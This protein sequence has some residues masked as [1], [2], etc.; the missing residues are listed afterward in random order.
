[1]KHILFLII[2]FFVQKNTAQTANFEW[3]KQTGGTSSDISWATATDAS[4]NVYTTG[5]FQGTV[6][7]DP[8]TNVFNLTANG[9]ACAFILKLDAAGN[10]VWATH[11]QVAVGTS[12]GR[13]I[14]VD[15][16]GNV[17]T[18]GFFRGDVDFDPSV[19][20][21]YLNSG[22]A[23]ISDVFVSKL[24]TAG[25]FVWA[26]KLGSASNKD[27]A[28]GIAL[29]SAGNVYTTGVFN[30]GAP[31]IV[32]YAF[33]SKLN[34]LGALVWTSNI[35]NN[36]NAKSAN[37][38]T[39]DALGNIYTTGYF[40]G[41]CLFGNTLLQSNTNSEDIFVTKLDNFGNTV[42]AKA[43]VSS[44]GS[45]GDAAGNAIVTDAN[46]NVYV[47]GH[48][49]NTTDFDPGA[50]NFTL[51]PGDSPY[52]K[53]DA[54]ALK[55]DTGGNFVWAKQITNT[56]NNDN[57]FAITLDATGNVYIAGRYFNTCDFD[58]GAGTFIVNGNGGYVSKLDADGNFILAYTMQGGSLCQ[59]IS[60]NALGNIYTTG[61]LNG[62]T[63]DFDPSASFYNLTSTGFTDG[64][65]HKMC[66]SP[67]VT[68]NVLPSNSICPGTAIT[69]TGSGASTYSWSGPGNPIN[70]VA[71]TPTASATY[72]LT[73]THTNGCPT[74]IEVPITVLP[75]P[76]ITVNSGT[77]CAGQTFTI[78]PTGAATYNIQ[79]GSNVVSPTV[80]TT[81]SVVGT[82]TFGCSSNTETA[83]VTVVNCPQATHLNFDG[84]ND[85]VE[86]PH[87]AG[88]NISN[89]ITIETWI[90]TT[91]PNEH[92]ITTKNEG[93][94]YLAI[95]G[96]NLA[97]GKLTFYLSGISPSG[98]TIGST[99]VSD[100]NWHHVAATYDG[101]FIKLYVDG[102][103]DGQ[104]AQTGT[105]STVLDNIAIGKRPGFNNTAI[106]NGSL[107][108]FRIWNTAR[109]QNEIV[110]HMNCEIPNNLT[111]LIANYH[112]N[113]GFDNINNST[114][115]SLIDSSGNTHNGTLN[116]FALSAVTSNWQMGSPITSGGACATLF[117]NKFNLENN[118]EVYPNPS[119]GIFT[120]SIIED[121]S[122]E[123]Y[124]IIGKTIYTKK[125]IPGKNSIDISNY[126]SGL[127]LLNVK[128]ENSSITKKIIKE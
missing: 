40:K 116:N 12:L 85:W 33:V 99:T 4:G 119:N 32:E 26:K 47:A 73:A 98:W 37:A 44:Q 9:S 124:N 61:I 110:A 74:T 55:L 1:M 22:S 8:G 97:P 42:W 82:S 112:F 111:G 52:G 5:Q 39:L 86:V 48:F 105:I 80:T 18:T 13:S 84:I 94:W 92:Y 72:T 64:F 68:I 121:A 127:Y 79:G 128:T 14:A 81:Y 114:E 108:E 38:I 67:A 59:G 87:N 122:L 46:N 65:T 113:Q 17:F 62:L 51:V 43:I 41:N 54:F 103:L 7:F 10:F 15:A 20:Q 31:S 66:Q 69:L 53:T 93:A 45:S 107:D 89:N 6:D 78:T 96:G 34:S 118:V 91:N 70:G 24:D 2:V 63:N 83:T 3:V 49:M 101:A 126:Q 27:E 16:T 90:K 11:F 25:N 58:P 123:I 120:I 36:G 23:T 21:Y 56:T 102:I 28:Y 95:S 71:F 117:T 109:T 57:A 76:N 50:G 88:F 106:F 100:G 115:T 30:L 60:V 125:V 35:V 19:A 75:I 77:I 104:F 29:D